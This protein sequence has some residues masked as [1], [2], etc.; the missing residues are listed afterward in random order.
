MFRNND[1]VPEGWIFVFGSNLK[2]IHGA[3]AALHAKTLYGAIQGV[4]EG[5]MG[6]SYALATKRTPW[7]KMTLSEVEFSI[8]KFCEFIKSRQ[9]LNFYITRVGCNL[10]GFNDEQIS[11]LFKKHLDTSLTNFS[12][13]ANWKDLI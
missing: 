4:G 8:E 9:D 3:G 13:P 11:G 5:L 2:G 12:L 6:L 10:A 7:E 1:D